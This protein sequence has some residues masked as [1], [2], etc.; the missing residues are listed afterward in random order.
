MKKTAITL[1]MLAAGLP[2]L[3]ALAQAR[4]DLP[5]KYHFN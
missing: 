4:V 3:P 2:S 5:A 1:S